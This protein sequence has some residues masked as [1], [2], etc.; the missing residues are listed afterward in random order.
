MAHSLNKE[1]M[2]TRTEVDNTLAI[3]LR[4]ADG[5]SCIYLYHLMKYHTAVARCRTNSTKQQSI[6]LL[7]F[8]LVLLACTLN[9]ELNLSLHMYYCSY[10]LSF[11]IYLYIKHDLTFDH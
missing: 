4:H 5:V 11:V 10:C 8:M 1:C 7:I 6:I 3:R 2:A 9:K